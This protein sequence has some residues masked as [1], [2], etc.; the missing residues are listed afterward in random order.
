M[1]RT[2][3]AASV[4]MS[5][6]TLAQPDAGT[7]SPA[8]VDGLKRDLDAARKEMKEMREEMRAQQANQASAQGWQDDWVPEKRK[9]ETFV[10]N[11]YLRMRPEL[12]YHMDLGRGEDP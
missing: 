11:G 9:L 3:L 2:L 4:V 7:D 5:S 1:L 6:W 8:D 10:P 12:L